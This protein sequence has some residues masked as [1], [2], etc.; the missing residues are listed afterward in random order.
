MRTAT[1]YLI[2][3]KM[4]FASTAQSL[5]PII[6]VSRE[7]ANIIITKIFKLKNACRMILTAKLLANVTPASMVTTAVCHIQRL[8]RT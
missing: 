7:Y 3:V 4:L 8:F 2:V 1:A 5:V 6:V